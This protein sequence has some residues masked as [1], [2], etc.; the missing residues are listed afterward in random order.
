MEIIQ[1]EE[2]RNG[3]Q[4]SFDLL[5]KKIGCV[6]IGTKE[7]FPFGW[8]KAAK[9]RTVWRIL[10]ELIIQTLE[11]YH[12]EFNLEY[13]KP[14]ESEVSIFDFECKLK[15]NANPVYVNIKSAVKGG[16]I[17]KDD[18]SKAVGL[19][20]FYDEDLNRNFFAAT[21]FIEFND[22]M[23][24]NV[25]NA[26]VFPLVWLPDIYVNPSNNGNLQSACFKDI[27]KAVKRSNKDFYPLFLKAVDIAKQKKKETNK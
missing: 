6:Q 17:N 23:S 21:F 19:K 9:G 2:L 7:Q 25:T 14:S 24:I 27:S 8:R 5:I 26:V 10:E 4:E 1:I 3:I 20:S 16:R 18:I 15:N 22:D 11:K 13:V 12:S